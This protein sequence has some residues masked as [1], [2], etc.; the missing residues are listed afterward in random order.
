MNLPSELFLLPEDRVSLI[1]SPSELFK[2]IR[3][4]Q[5]FWF[6]VRNVFEEDLSLFTFM[7]PSQADTHVLADKDSV[8]MTLSVSN[9]AEEQIA[10]PLKDFVEHVANLHSSQG[11]QREFEV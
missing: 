8:L 10:L 1:P 11:F 6:S 2:I 7:L 3:G 5:R 9:L 4:L